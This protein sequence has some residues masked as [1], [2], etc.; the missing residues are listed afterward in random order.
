MRCLG[1]GH[2]AVPAA[3]SWGLRAELVTLFVVVRGRF[4]G[5]LLMMICAYAGSLFITESLFV[6]LK[7]KLLTLPWFR[8]AW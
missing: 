8:V 2:C 4:I 6:D 1:R 7:P 5:G 3:S